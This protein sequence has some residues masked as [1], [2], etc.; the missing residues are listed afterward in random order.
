[1]IDR[2]YFNFFPKRPIKESV[3]S[4]FNLLFSLHKN[5]I[6][7]SLTL[8]S[9]QIALGLAIWP[10]FTHALKDQMCIYIASSDT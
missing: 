4:R 10:T 5:R 6:I 3:E 8:A 1:M 7:V 9:E 2:D